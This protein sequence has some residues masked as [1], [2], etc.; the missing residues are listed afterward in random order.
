MGNEEFPGRAIFSPDDRRLCQVR[1]RRGSRHCQTGA[2]NDRRFDELVRAH[3][4]SLV[5]FARSLTRDR[6][7]ADEAVQD[8][9]VRAWR[10]IDSFDAR[11]SFEG[12]LLQICRRVIIDNAAHAARRPPVVDPAVLVER[13]PAINL[14]TSHD[15]IELLRQLPFAQTEVLVLTGVLGYTYDDAATMLDVP[16][17]TIRSRVARGRQALAEVLTRSQDAGLEHGAA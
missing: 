5:I 14:D 11:G 1:S 16:I 9:L 17:G 3:S 13:A 6:R 7:A 4:P 15:I 10:Y 8:T 2:V 12:W